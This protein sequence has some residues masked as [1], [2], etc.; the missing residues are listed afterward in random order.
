MEYFRPRT[1][2]EY[3]AALWRR[4]LLIVLTSAVILKAGF[5]LTS[6]IPD[7]Y[8]SRTLVLINN[9]QPEEMQLSAVQIASVQEQILSRAG[10]ETLVRRHRLNTEKESTEAAAQ[11]LRKAIRLETKLRDYYPQL[12][13]SIT[14]SFRDASP[15]VTQTVL[16]DL[17]TQ[18]ETANTLVKK[19]LSAESERMN[20]ELAELEAPLRQL[21]ERRAAMIRPLSASAIRDTADQRLTRTTTTAAVETLG[22]K[23]VAL[24]QQIEAQK[25][26]IA[27]QQKVVKNTPPPRDT[28]YGLLLIRKTEIEA[29][30]RQF[31]TQYTDK[32]PRVI[33]ART[34]LAEINRQLEAG[35]AGGGA[36]VASSEAAELRTLQRD[37][38][39]METEL[40]IAQRE[41]ERRRQTLSKLGPEQEAPKAGEIKEA[42]VSTASVEAE[43][44]RLSKRYYWLL[45][46]QFALQKMNVSDTAPAFFQVIDWPHLPREPVSPN[47]LYL[48]LGVLVAALLGGLL[49]AF[50]IELPRLFQ[51][52]DE[53]DIQFYLGVPVLGLIPETL[54][55]V[56]RSRKWRLRW[57][58]G[59]AVA[60]LVVMVGTMLAVLLSRLN[61]LQMFINR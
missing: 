35:N 13:E 14:I 8:E 34:Q 29:Q 16:N 9:R 41:L 61:V 20:A 28:A 60:L 58:S 18:F 17:V 39:R 40:T 6:V 47:R 42:E 46:K 52:R 50:A 3:V 31:E 4:K 48:R 51:I 19:Q 27:E 43:Y 11:R 30:L 25:R 44:D 33:Q 10:L 37:L 59:L 2:A 12:P 38:T 15:K 36:A 24:E 54:T 26:L 45:D 56:E 23:V 49:L 21:A 1:P 57:A 22:D 53:R 55:P 7:Q 5:L 32:N